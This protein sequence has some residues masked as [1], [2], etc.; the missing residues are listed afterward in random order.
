[1]TIDM[2][3]PV[4]FAFILGALLVSSI[5]Y[6]E[7]ER[8]ACEIKQKQLHNAYCYVNYGQLPL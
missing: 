7:I 4:Q 6:I 3:L 5:P 8:F 1:M 2:Y